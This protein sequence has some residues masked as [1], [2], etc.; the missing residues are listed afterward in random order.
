[1]K[2]L[3]VSSGDNHVF[4]SSEWPAMMP[5]LP[6]TSGGEPSFLLQMM[7]A[8]KLNIGGFSIKYLLTHSYLHS[9]NRLRCG[10]CDLLW[11]RD[12]EERSTV[13][14]LYDFWVNQANCST[15]KIGLP[16]GSPPA[17]FHIRERKI[18]P[19]SP[20]NDNSK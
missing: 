11:K 8:C 14:D 5:F 17:S 12:S 1:M 2:H 9:S 4:F 6:A 19:G 7:P 16:S 20:A 15:L 18:M 3:K 13:T 10:L